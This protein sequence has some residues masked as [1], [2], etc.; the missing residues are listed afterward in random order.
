MNTKKY[1]ISDEDKNTLFERT[2][3]KIWL[4]AN[5]LIIFFIFLSIIVVFLDSI[6][7]LN[8]KYLIYF[9]IIDFIISSIFLIEYF[10]RWI[11]SSHKKKF[12]FKILNIFDL[13]SFLPFFILVI[14]YW[15][16]T[17]SIFV[18]FRI[19][20][21]FR[22]FEL[23]K[24][25]NIIKNLLKSVYKHR[26]EYISWISVILIIL[27]VS[28]TIVYFSEQ[29]WWD[30]STFNTLPNTLRWAIVTMSTTGYGDM[31]PITSIWKIV[32]SFLMFLWPVVIAI[33]SSITVIIFLE[34]SKIVQFSKRNNICKNCWSNNRD[35]AFY[36]SNCWEK[37]KN[38]IPKI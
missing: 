36:C 13:L 8:E 9:F 5:Y 28:S 10:Y 15:V 30:A 32:A 3:T 24:R 21:V 25:I 7:S 23:I 17:Y 4:Y 31:L 29:K 16:G 20:R 12:P 37:L 2:N 22:I 38:K 1:K 34:T 6:P 33:I 26:I 35:K 11:R 18:V 27:I 14:I 19:F